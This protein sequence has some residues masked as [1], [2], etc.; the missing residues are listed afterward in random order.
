MSFDQ[1]DH[2]LF[3]NIGSVSI[4]LLTHTQEQGLTEFIR[5]VLS[6][7][8][9]LVLS[10]LVG[11]PVALEVTS[12]SLQPLRQ[13]NTQ[14]ASIMSPDV[15]TVKQAFNGS[16]TGDAILLLDYPVAVTLANLLHRYPQVSNSYLALSDSEALTEVGNIFLNGYLGILSN[17]WGRKISFSMPDFRVHSLDSL[18]TSLIL[19]RNELR[20]V[21]ISGVK[22]KLYNQSINGYLLFVSGVISL[23]CLVKAVESWADLSELEALRV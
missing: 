16:I 19:D 3:D 10:E 6:H 11:T 18:L 9:E 15:V 8:T 2:I 21:L 20:Y 22:F 4:M 13:L 14:F 5:M 1:A 12:V 17:I 7:G 23:S